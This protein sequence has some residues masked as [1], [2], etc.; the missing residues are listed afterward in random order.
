MN[1]EVIASTASPVFTTP[2]VLRCIGSFLIDG[3]SVRHLFTYAR[4]NRVFCNAASY[5]VEAFRKSLA[6]RDANSVC[7]MTLRG[8]KF[9]LPPF[10]KENVAYTLFITQ[11]NYSIKCLSHVDSKIRIDAFEILSRMVEKHILT[12][13]SQRLNI[14]VNQAI[15]NITGMDKSIKKSALSLLTVMVQEQ[16]LTSKSS[17]FATIVKLAIESSSYPDSSVGEDALRLLGAMINRKILTSKSPQI[18]A[19][20]AQAVNTTKEEDENI[21]VDRALYNTIRLYNGMVVFKILTSESESSH[22]DTIIS[23]ATC[24]LACSSF[25][26]DI[27]AR[28]CVKNM[29]DQEI[30]THDSPK[31]KESLDWLVE[32][33][34]SNNLEDIEHALVTLNELIK[35]NILTKEYSS[36][37][38]ISIKVK[39]FVEHKEYL[40]RIAATD[41]YFS[42]KDRGLWT[43]ERLFDS[44]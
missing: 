22:I 41:L 14:I 26:T 36:I 13:K 16:V 2:D 29:L 11:L 19:V 38:E 40:V 30:M 5:C 6:Q 44:S 27:Y 7:T 1:T 34:S 39:A 33:L 24:L 25:G 37:K 32:G 10:T 4:V 8:N 23:M 31:L 3:K 35:D 21:P 43:G 42:M 20:I 15:V 28:K 12:I 18:E 9:P 17:Q